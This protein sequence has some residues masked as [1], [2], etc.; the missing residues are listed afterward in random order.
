MISLDILKKSLNSPTF[1]S[2]KTSSAM[3]VLIE[4]YLQKAGVEYYNE[5]I[6][7]VLIV[8]ILIPKYKIVVEIEGPAHWVFPSNEQTLNNISRNA[9]IKACGY[10]LVMI[11][12]LEN[13]LSGIEY[14]AKNLNEKIIND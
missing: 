10:N 2:K 5:S 9:V 4:D 14:L 3:H 13:N 8:D 6:L 12:D 7:G 11:G 1:K